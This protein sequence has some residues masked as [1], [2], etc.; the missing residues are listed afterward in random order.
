MTTFSYAAPPALGTS[1]VQH[2]IE[3]NS[4]R[5]GKAV[6]RSAFRQAMRRPHAG[7]CDRATYVLRAGSGL[8]ELQSR[9]CTAQSTRIRANQLAATPHLC[10][11]MLHIEFTA[12][13]VRAEQLSDRTFRERDLPACRA[14]RRSPYATIRIPG[15]QWAS[16]AADPGASRTRGIKRGLPGPGASHAHSH[17]PHSRHGMQAAN[18][19][20]WP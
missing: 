4:I 16:G 8:F 7:C 20:A 19:S 3:T 2:R 9:H 12:A 5:V 1:A 18:G 10:C 11:F 14:V 6:D 15:K 17:G 13:R